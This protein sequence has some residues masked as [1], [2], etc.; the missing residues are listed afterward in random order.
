[1]MIME[2]KKILFDI[3]KKYDDNS[4]NPLGNAIDV[5]MGWMFD[6]GV[7]QTEYLVYEEFITKSLKEKCS[8]ELVESY[9][10]ENI[11]NDNKEFLYVASTEEE[12]MSIKFFRDIYK[13]YTPTNINTKCYGYSFLNKLYI[14]RKRETDL[15]E[16][17][18]KYYGQN[19]HRIVK[20]VGTG[21]STAKSK[22]AEKKKVMQEAIKKESEKIF[23]PKSKK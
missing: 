1:M 2:K 7:Y 16:V 15:A 19:R 13:F 17:K 6:E 20:G 4:S 9:D 23:K 18:T 12:G 5:H 11:F 14:F 22:V 10:F 21:S 8:M 3:I